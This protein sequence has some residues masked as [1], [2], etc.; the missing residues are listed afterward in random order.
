[1]QQ[2]ALRHRCLSNALARLRGKFSLAYTTRSCCSFSMTL[3]N[4]KVISL[5]SAGSSDLREWARDN[6]YK[7]DP[8]HA[9]DTGG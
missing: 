8:P 1:M 4:I 5:N 3:S 7:N 9:L 6:H 2:N